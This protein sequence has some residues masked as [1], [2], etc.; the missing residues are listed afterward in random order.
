MKAILVVDDEPHVRAVVSH[1]AESFGYH[2]HQA[3][4][5]DA[6]LSV[7]DQSDVSV[8]VCDVRMPGRDGLWLTGEIRGRHPE[9]AIILAT[10][11]DDGLVAKRGR[12]LGAMDYLVKPFGGDRLAGALRKGI[13]WHRDAVATREWVERLRL[14]QRDRR[15]RLETVLL[16]AN[17]ERGASALERLV[18]WR[19]IEDPEGQAAAERVMRFAIATGQRLGLRDDDIRALEGAALLHDIGLT[20]MPPAL[21]DK[22]ADFTVDERALVRQHPLVA[23]NLLQRC[24]ELERV[25]SVVL[26]AYEGYSGAG[27]PQGLTGEEIPLTSRVLAVAIAYQGMMTRRPHRAALPSGEAVLELFRCREAQ[28]DP[29]V[30]EAF[31]QMLTSH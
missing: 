9:T 16:D 28:F 29:A 31:V 26:S 14:E 11:A 20:T 10:G 1:W 27:Y 8:A 23:F 13:D 4:D 21:M 17:A 2:A 18:E 19:R 30:V 25:A 15:E 12:D 22:P 24:S 6:A 5:A 3:S 7:M